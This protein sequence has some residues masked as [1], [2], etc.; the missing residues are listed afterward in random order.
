L[1]GLAPL[2]LMGGEA[3]FGN[4]MPPG[5]GPVQAAAATAATNEGILTGQGTQNMSYVNTGALP[6]GAQDAITQAANAA[7]AQVL[8][9][10]ASQ[11]IPPGSSMEIQELGAVDQNAA[12]QKFNI[13]NNLLQSGI[14][15]FNAAG[16]FG[17]Q[18]NQADLELMTAQIQQE[19]ELETALAG[20]AGAFAAGGAGAA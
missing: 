19:Q 20:F 18:V 1:I 9:G 13:Q 16:G 7:K 2:A 15:Q 11:G 10:F 8:S 17:N 4:N 6:A 12:V 3:L 14:S 5:S